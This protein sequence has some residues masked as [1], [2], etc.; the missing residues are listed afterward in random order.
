M[1]SHVVEKHRPSEKFVM[2]LAP[3]PKDASSRAARAET[4]CGLA[5][6]LRKTL[7]DTPRRSTPY[8]MTDLNHWMSITRSDDEEDQAVPRLL[9]E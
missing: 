9:R 6:W 8:M 4:L 5:E 1:T 3:K 2:F 7:Q